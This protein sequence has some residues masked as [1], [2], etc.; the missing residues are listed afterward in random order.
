MPSS[1]IAKDY[2]N[3]K[4]SKCPLKRIIQFAMEYYAAIKKSRMDFHVWMWKKQ[5][6][7]FSKKIQSASG[8]PVCAHTYMYMYV[9]TN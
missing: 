8:F 2:K 3:Y 7:Q 9:S 5:D 4:Q 6:N 1:V